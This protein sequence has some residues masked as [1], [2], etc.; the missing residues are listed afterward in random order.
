MATLKDA[1]KVVGQEEKKQNPI[2]N[3]LCLIGF[4]VMG[5]G[6]YSATSDA[7]TSISEVLPVDQTVVE[8]VVETISDAA[9]LQGRKSKKLRK[10]H[11]LY[12]KD[13]Y[14]KTTEFI[15]NP[16]HRFDID[17][18]SAYMRVLANNRKMYEKY[19]RKLKNWNDPTF[20]MRQVA[21]HIAETG[22]L[23]SNFITKDT[24]KNVGWNGHAG[25]LQ[26]ED[27]K[28]GCII[29]GDRF[30]NSERRLP[31]AQGRI[32]YEVDMG[33]LLPPMT[34][35]RRGEYRLLFSSDGLFYGTTDH[36][37]TFFEITSNE[38][39]RGVRILLGNNRTIGPPQV[40]QAVRML[41]Y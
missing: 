17:Y 20:L 33:P 38:I 31:H 4:L 19:L 2:L 11:K 23:P 29:G 27:V 24:A 28:P 7:G 39:T 26:H 41:A 5:L 32:W 13:D 18:I 21:L 30:K 1:Q 37:D 9:D 40:Q 10:K 36:Y 16:K 15:N 3:L 8:E 22:W 25:N 6:G 14:Q 35:V 34:G 12:T